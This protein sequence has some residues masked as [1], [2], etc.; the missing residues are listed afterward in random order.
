MI[1]FL[2][3][4]AHKEDSRGIMKGLVN[5]GKWEELNFF[6]T[7][8]GQIRGNHYHKKTDELFIILK[9]KIEIEWSKVDL[10]GE[11]I[12]NL[13][14]TT[15]KMGDVFIIKKNIRHIFNILEDSEWINGL[16]QKMDEIHPDICI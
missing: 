5:Q 6:S 8:A 16:S 12:H 9:G 14:K 1:I 2:K 15:V 13:N 10:K 4:Y 7:F 3:N 11:T